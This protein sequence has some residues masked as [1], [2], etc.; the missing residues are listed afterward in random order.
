[1]EAV[2]EEVLV[3]ELTNVRSVANYCGVLVTHLT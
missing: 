2:E 3:V 1:M